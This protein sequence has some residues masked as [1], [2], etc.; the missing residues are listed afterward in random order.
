MRAE[1]V[2]EKEIEEIAEI[3]S[4]AHGTERMVRQSEGPA[5]VGATP[6]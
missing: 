6:D 5:I 2:S 1:K 3:Q 4:A